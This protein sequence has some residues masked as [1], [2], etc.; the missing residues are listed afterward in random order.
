MPPFRE[1]IYL[2]QTKGNIG[3]GDTASKI[4]YKNYYA[5]RQSGAM[6]ELFLLDDDYKPIGLRETAGPGEFETRFQYQPEL[7]DKYQAIAPTL[8]PPA[9]PPKPA[10]KPKPQPKP[11]VQEFKPAEA[12]AKPAKPGPEENQESGNWWEMTSKG[13]SNLFKK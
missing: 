1:G 7:Q 12:F 2:Q 5:V 8:G 11:A 6:L 4:T 3:T 10:P 9:A 13:S